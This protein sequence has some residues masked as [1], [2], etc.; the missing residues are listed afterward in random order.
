MKLRALASH[1]TVLLIGVILATAAGALAR[2]SKQPS[3][4]ARVSRLEARVSRL[5]ARVSRL[6]DRHNVLQSS[7]QTFCNTL[8]FT[9]KD[10]IQDVQAREMFVRLAETCWTHVGRSQ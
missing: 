8:K 6:E 4:A 3:L 5:E 1:V 2:P 9:D 10:G 7:Y